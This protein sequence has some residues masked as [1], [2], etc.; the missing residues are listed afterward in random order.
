MEAAAHPWPTLGVLML[1]D[2]LVSKEQLEAILNEQ[3][4]SRQQRMSGHRLGEVLIDRGLVTPTE[5]AKL[6]AEQYE[7]PFTE[8]DPTDVDSRVA[9]RFSE[10]LA[11]RIS[12]IPI[13]ARP[14]GSC[15]LAIADPATVLFSDELRRVLG[16]SLQFVVVG[17]D[18]M[19]AAIA[20]VFDRADE[21]EVSPEPGP[22]YFEGTVVELRQEDPAE[23]TAPYESPPVAAHASPTTHHS[24]PLGA[25]LVREGLLSEDELD[26]ALAQ[27]RLSTSWRLG[28]ILVNRGVVTPAGIARV[29]AE[30][31]ELP[32]VDLANAYVDPA[33]ASRLPREIA[34]NFPAVPIAECSDGSLQVAIAD[35]TNVYYSAELRDALGVALTFVVAAPGSR[36]RPRARPGARAHMGARRNRHA[37]LVGRARS[38][39]A[40]SRRGRRGRRRVRRRPPGLRPR[41]RRP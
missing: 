4:D 13:S 20:F 1:R 15:V 38:R 30:Q 21:L 11:R 41:Y 3:R 29:I 27:Q 22:G 37:G 34:R 24:P 17:P 6:V 26:A 33:V 16:P 19:E 36:V 32:F 9:R 2:G 23:D 14:D 8:L 25:L 5:V 39:I 35:P 7:L 31:Y 28:E 10:E 18:A 12:A 40:G